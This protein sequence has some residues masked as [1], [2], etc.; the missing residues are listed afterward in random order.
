VDDAD[1]VR[2]DSATHRVIVGY[3]SGALVVIDPGSRTK[4]AEIP[5]KSHP[6]SFQLAA[7][8][9]RIFVNLSDA[10]EIAVVDRNT[11]A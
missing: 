4:I 5:L 9:P 11:N 10:H 2:V 8:G 6:E 3:G 7:T 1:N